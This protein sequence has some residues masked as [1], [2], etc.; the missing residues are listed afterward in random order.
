MPDRG[1]R[2]RRTT[3]LRTSSST[4]HSRYVGYFQSALA[5]IYADISLDRVYICYFLPT[6]QHFN[7]K[8]GYTIQGTSKRSRIDLELEIE[9]MGAHLNAYTSREQTVYYAKCFSNDIERC[10]L[11]FFSKFHIFSWKQLWQKEGWA[12]LKYHSCLWHSYIMM[13]FLENCSLSFQNF[14]AHRFQRLKFSRTFCCTANS[15]SETSRV[16]G[17]WFWGRCRKSSRYVVSIMLFKN[18]LHPLEVTGWIY[19]FERRAQT[20]KNEISCVAKNANRK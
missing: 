2:R 8:F 5:S 20:E 13:C 17:E 15:T 18:N 7:K 1:M 11:F 19:I 14:W 9:N 6:S 10:R 16:S 3:E 12:I 4:W